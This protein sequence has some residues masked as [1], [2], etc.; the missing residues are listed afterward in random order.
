M[1]LAADASDNVAVDRVEFFV[2]GIIAGTDYLAPYNTAWD[3]ATHGDGPVA[4]TARAVDT[5]AN[6]TLSASS[7]VIVDN[8]AP[9][10]T[11]DLGPAESD[12]APEATFMFSANEPDATF[13]CALDAGDFDECLSPQ[14]Y[15]NLAVRRSH[16][17]C[18]CHRRRRQHRPNTRAAQLDCTR[19]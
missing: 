7:M 3:S 4:I 12:N 10:T 16:L 6:V 5:S 1:T 8:T 9:D 13:D 14:S 17:P 19:R 15:S 18:D 2:D 11:I